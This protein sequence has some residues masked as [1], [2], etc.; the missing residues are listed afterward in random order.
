[1]WLSEMFLFSRLV[2]KGKASGCSLSLCGVS[3][4]RALEGSELLGITTTTPVTARAGPAR[5]GAGP[6]CSRNLNLRNRV[7]PN[8]VLDPQQTQMATYAPARSGVPRDEE[9]LLAS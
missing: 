6:W 1:M 2:S 8:D 9:G 3:W 5:V 7:D 4:R